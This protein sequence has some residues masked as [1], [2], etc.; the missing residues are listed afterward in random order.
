MVM[1]TFN[2]YTTLKYKKKVIIEDIITDVLGWCIDKWG[3]NGRRTSKLGIEID[4][5]RNDG[6]TMGEYDYMDNLI[7]IYPRNNKNV[8]EL[9][10]SV[11]HEF[12]HQRQKM[13]KYHKVLKSTGYSDHPY[14]VEAFSIAKEY[15]KECWYSIRGRF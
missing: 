11:I 1:K 15:R 13:S 8:R 10:D 4:W 12:T 3:L 5:D 9:V 14:E 7:I 2:L 6:G